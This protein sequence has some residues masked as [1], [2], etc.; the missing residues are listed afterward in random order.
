[1][2]IV[3]KYKLPPGIT[4]N[5]LP[6]EK[7]TEE[8]YSKLGVFKD[9]VEFLG[10]PEVK[11]PTPAGNEQT[12]GAK[13]PEKDTKTPPKDKDTEPPKDTKTSNSSTPSNKK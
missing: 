10:K 4:K 8:E 13:T 1:M 7:I 3:I 2:D 12:G 6:G 5:T 9:R 11:E